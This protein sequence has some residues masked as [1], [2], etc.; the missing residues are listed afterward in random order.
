MPLR[1]DGHR[2]AAKLRRNLRPR[3]EQGRWFGMAGGHS[4][5]YHLICMNC[6]WVMGIDDWPVKGLKA[7]P[8]PR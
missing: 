4:L 2:Q 7:I 8:A 1:C 3:E 6:S 5:K